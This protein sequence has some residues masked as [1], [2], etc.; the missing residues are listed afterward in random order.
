MLF[1]F[2]LPFFFLFFSFPGVA[3]SFSITQPLSFLVALILSLLVFFF[4]GV[5]PS[6]A[7][8]IKNSLGT[9]ASYLLAVSLAY[10]LAYR[11]VKLR[12]ELDF[13][14]FTCCQHTT[15]SALF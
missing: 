13:L 11:R 6:A 7:V 4:A 9:A 14:G 15:P 8:K 10:R 2:V 1:S 5:Q 3:G 12:S